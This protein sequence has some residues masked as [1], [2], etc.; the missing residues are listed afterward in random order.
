VG[1]DWGFGAHQVCVL[2]HDGRVL[3]E[4]NI[5]HTGSAIV[6]LLDWLAAL[7][8]DHPEG[9]AVAIELPRGALVESLVERGFSVFFINPKQLDRFRDRHTVA[10]AKDDR[11]DA[12]VLADSLRTDESCFR[13][14]R[15]DD[16]RIIQI[17]ELSRMD[18]DLGQEA[19]RLA[20]RLRDQLHRFYP[21]L[22]RLSPAADEPWLWS[23]VELAPTPAQGVRLPPKRV[24]KLLHEHRIRRF[25]AGEVVAEL[26]APAL[27]VAPGTIE[28]AAVHIAMLV[29]RLRLVHAQRA[30]CAHRIDALLD[31][32]ETDRGQNVEHHDVE[33]LRSLP[34]VGR[35]VAATVLAEAFQPLV[36][37]DYHALR[38]FAGSA[39]VTRQ[40]GKRRCVSMRRGC[41]VR[42]RYAVYHWSRAAAQ[43]DPRAR[44]I[45]TALR[46]RGHT[47]GRALRQLGDRL[48]AI[49]VA[50]L[51][52]GTLYDPNRARRVPLAR[53]PLP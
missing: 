22:L 32:L 27:R 6:E 49:L 39:P 25:K 48:L 18:E 9:A 15:I 46:A 23:L 35:V 17:R 3:Q 53:A 14:V 38:T 40:S 33:I 8:G 36:E 52:S 28:A 30:E 2:D 10:G 42:L 1:I 29:P 19:S 47:H 37:R 20:N 21:Q 50:M 11:R 45:Y 43:H 13:R 51:E 44:E 31:S 16:P 5:E 12:W 24:E 4:R 34:G 7:S 26:R 41:N